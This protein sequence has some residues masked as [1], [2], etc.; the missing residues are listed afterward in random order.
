M[1]NNIILFLFLA[2]SLFIVGCDDDVVASNDDGAPAP[3]T[4]V[5]M[6][7]SGVP[8]DFASN[9]DLQDSF[10]SD[11]ANT[12]GMSDPE[13]IQILS[14]SMQRGDVSIELLFLESSDSSAP[15][16]SDLLSS[17]VEVEA[18]GDYAATVELTV[19]DDSQS[20]Q[21]M[22]DAANQALE[23]YLVYV[24]NCDSQDDCSELGEFNGDIDFLSPM[25]SIH[26]LYI[27]ALDFDSSNPEA[28]FGAAI[29]GLLTITTD[30]TLINFLDDWDDWG[31]DNNYFPS[32]S[33]DVEVD[34][35]SGG[36]RELVPGLS[37]GANSFFM[38]RDMDIMSFLPL[39][40]LFKYYVTTN[41]SESNANS[42][43]DRNHPSIINKTS[44]K[45]IGVYFYF[46]IVI[47]LIQFLL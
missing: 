17:V 46:K 18:V 1:K 40:H 32:I 25:E 42:S 9:A 3:V 14:I 10:K 13:R 6:G 11:L 44:I 45:L 22:L 24:S 28:N 2:L 20:A 41:N 30:Q 29:T 34:G 33:E 19:A 26:G 8:D 36:S 5:S 31:E 39:N 23:D 37:L 27:N 16:I 35:R 38:M 21:Y 15:S 47:I 7:L 12:L 43:S 4:I